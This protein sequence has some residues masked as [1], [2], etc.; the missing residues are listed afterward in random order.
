MYFSTSHTSNTRKRGAEDELVES[1]HRKKLK[2]LVSA[3]AAVVP[4]VTKNQLVQSIVPDIAPIAAYKSLDVS[5]SIN[6]SQAT[7]IKGSA[8]GKIKKKSSAVKQKPPLLKEDR[9]DAYIAYL[10]SKL[11]LDKGGKKKGKKAI[12]EDGLDGT[13]QCSSLPY[14]DLDKSHHGF[15]SHDLGGF[16]R[17]ANH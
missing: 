11:S 3:T 16:V 2:S 17:G 15:R 10:E 4:K 5:P 7:A 6:L 14:F 1:P 9:E 13:L 8:L 12:E